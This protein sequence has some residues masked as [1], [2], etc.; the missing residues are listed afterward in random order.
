MVSGC[1]ICNQDCSMM[2]VRKGPVVSVQLLERY[3][4]FCRMGGSKAAHCSGRLCSPAD[5]WQR[6]L[7]VH[8]LRLS[9]WLGGLHPFLT[10]G[11][12]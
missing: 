6:P 12:D 3:R 4:H 7:D 10:A 8:S 2:A 1:K 5:A 9:G 11:R